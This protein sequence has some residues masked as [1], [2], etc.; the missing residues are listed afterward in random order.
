[1]SETMGPIPYIVYGALAGAAAVVIVVAI[2]VVR[3]FISWW[4]VM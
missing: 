4:D 3:Y 1:M 2:I